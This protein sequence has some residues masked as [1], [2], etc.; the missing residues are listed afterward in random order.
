MKS[1]ILDLHNKLVS[2][3]VKPEDLVNNAKALYEK[4]KKLNSIITPIFSSNNKFDKNEILSCIPYSLKDNVST[5]GILTT[6]GSKFLSKYV[7][8]YSATVYNLLKQSGATLL[9]KDNMDEFGLGGTGLHSAYGIVKNPHDES[10][11]AGGSSS[12]SAV[13]VATGI[14]AFAIGTD[15]G[16]SV[17][18]P[19]SLCGVVGYKPTYGAISR[20]GVLPYSPS[21]DH[22]GILTKYVADAT[23]VANR[24]FK[25][26]SKDMTSTNLINNVKLENLKTQNGIN[27]VVIKDLLSLLDKKHADKFNELIA[28]LE[29]N[30]HKIK[31]VDANIQQ[32]KALSFVYKTISF[33]EAYSC[34]SNLTG[35]VFGNDISEIKD[36][37]EQTIL[38]N[39][40]S[41]LGNEIKRRFIIGA[42]LSDKKH[43]E[44]LSLGARQLRKQFQDKELEILKQGDCILMPSVCGA[45]PSISQ[46]NSDNYYDDWLMMSNMSGTP[47]ITVPFAK[48]DGMPWG[49]TVV[50]DVYKDMKL[51]NIAYTLENIIGGNNE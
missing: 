51:L 1:V 5:K 3:S 31:Y 40:T 11:I 49:L 26:D 19:A 16:D 39:R 12:G 38:K 41:G 14:S 43:F 30:G 9:S 25:F 28:K 6:G 20:Y 8:P 45:A 15:T 7:P 17:R 21:L 37:Y 10:K 46:P 22:V 13:N 27:F 32:L 29:A 47:S 34:Y 4:N 2:G 44:E 50:C 36:S 33:I 18:R 23:I 48:V 24:I 42:Y 35:F